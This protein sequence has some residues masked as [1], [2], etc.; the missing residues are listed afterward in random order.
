MSDAA[1]SVPKGEKTAS[2][3]GSNNTHVFP[4]GR[5]HGPSQI[6]NNIHR[7]FPLPLSQPLSAQVPPSLGGCS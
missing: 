6:H 3:R 2:P 4:N 5:R 7:F 1:G